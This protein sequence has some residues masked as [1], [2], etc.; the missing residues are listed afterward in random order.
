MKD[1]RRGRGRTW[2]CLEPAQ[3]RAREQRGCG[4]GSACL[5]GNRQLCPQLA[6]GVDRTRPCRAVNVPRRC[7][8]AC[9][10]A[11][12]RSGALASPWR[13]GF[14]LC[15]GRHRRRNRRPCVRGGHHRLMTP[16]SA[17]RRRKIGHA[18]RPLRGETAPARRCISKFLRPV[19]MPDGA[20]V[21][22]ECSGT[23]A[24][25]RGRW[26]RRQRR[27]DGRDRDARPPPRDRSGP[28]SWTSG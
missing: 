7:A 2:I 24:G 16:R 1:R 19:P 23:A 3:R 22:F 10:R 4:T 25:L 5:S 27:N 17:S 26:P 20:A 11:A 28:C 15:A 9:G 6:V 18:S 13:W 8:G 12:R 14:G 21:V